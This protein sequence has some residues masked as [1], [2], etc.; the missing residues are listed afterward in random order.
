MIKTGFTL[1]E[2]V[3]AVTIFTMVV[4]VISFFTLDISKF[5]FFFGENLIA[6][7]EIQQSL[8]G[9]IPEIRSMG[10]SNL[11]GYPIMAATAN[12]FTFYTDNDKDGLFERIRYYMDGNIFKKAVIKPTG[13]PLTYNPAEEKTFELVHYVTNANNI[14]SY[15]DNNYTGSES[16][17]P[18]PINIPSVKTIKSELIADQNPQEPPLPLS[19]SITAMI[20]NFRQ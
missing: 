14:F 19:F 12:S 1:I 9:M 7:Q 11:G 13:N 18:F 8:R 6:Q 4:L 10:P 20:R 15:F 3:I 16:S 17:L 2:I 5:S